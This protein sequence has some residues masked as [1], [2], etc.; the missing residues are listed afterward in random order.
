[1]EESDFYNLKENSNPEFKIHEKRNINYDCLQK[2]KEDSPKFSNDSN[3][4]PNKRNFYDASLEKY[5]IILSK[6]KEDKKKNEKEKI[7]EVK[8]S[9]ISSHSRNKEES[10]D[11]NTPNSYFLDE[12]SSHK[13]LSMRLEYLD[14]KQKHLFEQKLNEEISREFSLD[15]SEQKNFQTLNDL[16]SENFSDEIKAPNL[17]KKLLV[18]LNET[19]NNNSNFEKN[20]LEFLDIIS[21]QETLEFLDRLKKKKNE[22]FLYLSYFFN[23]LIEECQLAFKTGE[24]KD[25]LYLILQEKITTNNQYQISL[26]ALEIFTKENGLKYSV[27]EILEDIRKKMEKIQKEEIDQLVF[28]EINIIKEMLEKKNKELNEKEKNLINYE[29]EICERENKLQEIFDNLSQNSKMKLENFFKEQMSQMNKRIYLAEKN[30]K[31]KLKLI[32]SKIKEKKTLIQESSTKKDD[33]KY[34]SKIQSLEKNNE[35]LKLKIQELEKKIVQEKENSQLLSNKMN[36]ITLKN[37]N[38]EKIIKDL[39]KSTQSQENNISQSN[40]LMKNSEIVEKEENSNEEGERIVSKRTVIKKNSDD[41]IILFNLFEG[42]SSSL[43]TTLPI[44]LREENETS[45]NDEETK[46]FDLGSIFYPNFNKIVCNLIEMAP[47]INKKYEIKCIHNYIDFFLKMVTFAFM[48]KSRSKI[49]EKS[50]S[51][52]SPKKLIASTIKG[53]SLQDHVNEIMFLSSSI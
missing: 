25:L 31:S 6:L 3:N 37:T 13:E 19:I 42:I 27:I 11:L 28:D 43:K 14:A 4:I 22:N 10:F 36:K 44:F 35:F 51:K 33:L 12:N 18:S 2:P 46:N 1:M 50:N 20:E 45:L 17:K 23:E 34:K 21:D 38:Q 52:I 7:V 15:N 30:L 41:S 48:F 47:I 29:R 32:E 53:K 5:Q 9:F 16:T 24:E 8:N 26:N 39:Q 49:P 40:L